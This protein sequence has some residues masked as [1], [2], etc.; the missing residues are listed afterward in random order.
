MIRRTQRRPSVSWKSVPEYQKPLMGTL[1]V[2]EVG[3]ER[4]PGGMPALSKLAECLGAS[5]ELLI[6][7]RRP[8]QLRHTETP[9][10]K[11]F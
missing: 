4:G 11:I 6:T 8:R 9:I 3:L 7:L 5:P 10:G 2:L 1:A